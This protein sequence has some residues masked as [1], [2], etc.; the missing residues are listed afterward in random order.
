MDQMLA[1]TRLPF[2]W[3]DDLL[4]SS[5]GLFLQQFEYA[6]EYQKHLEDVW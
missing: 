5:L 4:F 6:Q 2:R 1:S 3:A